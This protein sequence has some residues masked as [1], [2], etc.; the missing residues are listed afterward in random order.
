MRIRKIGF[1]ENKF[2]LESKKNPK[3][4]KDKLLKREIEKMSKILPAGRFFD[5]EIR[6]KKNNPPVIPPVNKSPGK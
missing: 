1:A 2:C 5:F 3:Y 4:P 6:S